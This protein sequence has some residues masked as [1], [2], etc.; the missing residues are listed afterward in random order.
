MP[1][2][3]ASSLQSNQTV[4]VPDVEEDEDLQDADRNTEA[5]AALERKVHDDEFYD[6]PKIDLNKP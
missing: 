3:Q 2:V 1:G 5:K 6:P 4:D